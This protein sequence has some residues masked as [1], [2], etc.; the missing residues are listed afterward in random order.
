[1]ARPKAIA[2]H[3]TF[4]FHV[5]EDFHRVEEPF[6]SWRLAKFQSGSYPIL[7]CRKDKAGRLHPPSRSYFI[8][9]A[10]DQKRLDSLC[11]ADS[12]VATFSQ[13]GRR[14]SQGIC[15]SNVISQF[16]ADRS[17]GSPKLT[18]TTHSAG[19]PKL[20]AH[21]FWPTGTSCPSLRRWPPKTLTK[22]RLIQSRPRLKA[23]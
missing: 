5:I 17:V 9:E 6:A 18:C 21:V 7:Q 22:L 15:S 16:S 1:M 10:G 2:T 11:F 4:P 23:F 19:E 3:Q 14:F 20:L 8:G 12:S 13:P